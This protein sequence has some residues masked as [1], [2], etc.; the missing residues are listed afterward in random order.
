MNEVLLVVMY[1]TF[2]V[3]WDKGSIT[4]GIFQIFSLIFFSNL[5]FFFT[6][7]AILNFRLSSVVLFNTLL[8]MTSF[9]VMTLHFHLNNIYMNDVLCYKW[10]RD[11]DHD[12]TW[13]EVDVMNP[14]MHHFGF[15]FSSGEKVVLVALS[16]VV[17]SWINIFVLT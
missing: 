13:S 6:F 9:M 5:S 2:L 14:K 1:A 12:V 15:V 10:W 17:E 8:K 7:E 11:D 16:Q 4:D 3:L